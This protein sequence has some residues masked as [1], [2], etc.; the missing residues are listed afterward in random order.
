MYV[1]NASDFL[2]SFENENLLMINDSVIIVT[3]YCFI[4]KVKLY[5]FI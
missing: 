2:S 4:I 1:Y 3:L 5:K